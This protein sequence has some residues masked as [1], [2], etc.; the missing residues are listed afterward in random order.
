MIV[1]ERLVLRPCREADKPAFAALLSTPAMM[2]EL[3]G[4]R[5]RAAIDA[6]VD[7]RIADQARNGFSYWAV[8]RRDT[9]ELIGTAGLR[10][11]ADYPGTPVENMV[12]IGWRIAE[13][14]W[15]QGY[16][17][18]AAGASLAWGW[19]NID[20]PEIGAWTTIGNTRSWGL[21]RRLG[22]ARRPELDF[23]RPDHAP[24]DPA[25]AMIVHTLARPR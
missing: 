12:E 6:L 9:G 5:P 4:V 11:A 13:A 1:T 17:R 16:A 24:D 18:E 23:H 19:A 21:M 7:K 10:V 15:G 14:H 20:V 22:M 8:E 25:G 2:A 3:G